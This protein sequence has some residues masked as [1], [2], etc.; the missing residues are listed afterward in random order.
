MSLLT[1]NPSGSSH[2]ELKLSPI[3]GPQDTAC[4][5]PALFLSFSTHFVPAMLAHLIVTNAKH[6]PTWALPSACSALCP[7]SHRA[8]SSPA[9]PWLLNAP[10]QRPV[11]TPI[12]KRTSPSCVIPLPTL[13]S[14]IEILHLTKYISV[15]FCLPH[16]TGGSIK[17]GIF[18]LVHSCIFASERVPAI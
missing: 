5:D 4:S 12:S 14:F 18:P 10:L 17:A 11:L 6:S 16:W 1:Q 8:G 9:F 7:L 13:V 2:S 15:Y 3:S